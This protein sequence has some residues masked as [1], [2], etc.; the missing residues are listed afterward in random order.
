MIN[1]SD[2][3]FFDYYVHLHARKCTRTKRLYIFFWFSYCNW[4]LLFQVK[5]SGRGDSKTI[6]WAGLGILAT[7]LGEG[8]VR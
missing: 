7:S 4:L 2:N 3:E 5:M 6:V 8:V 1:N